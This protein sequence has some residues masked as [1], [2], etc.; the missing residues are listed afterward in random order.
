MS[1]PTKPAFTITGQVTSPEA[2]NGVQ[3]VAVF[4]HRYA[5]ALLTSSLPGALQAFTDASGRYSLGLDA[6]YY[7]IEVGVFLQTQGY[8]DFYYLG[9]PQLPAMTGGGVQTPKSANVI[10]SGDLSGFNLILPAG[11][12][13]QVG[14]RWVCN[15]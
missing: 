4:A 7:T 9:Q 6:G 12:A 15:L 5:S 13:K 3:G 11:A 2:P 14:G 8:C 1:T 10:V